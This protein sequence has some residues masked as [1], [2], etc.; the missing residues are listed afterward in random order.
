MAES[1]IDRKRV[2]WKSS[3]LDKSPMIMNMTQDDE[4][5]PVFHHEN[6]IFWKQVDAV[7]V[8]IFVCDLMQFLWLERIKNRRILH[9][10][11]K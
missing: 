3:F 11:W 1:L 6:S 10:Y 5:A 7:S 4:N 2:S 8:V 9:I